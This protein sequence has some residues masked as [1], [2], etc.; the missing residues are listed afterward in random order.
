MTFQ[1][2]FL[3][4]WTIYFSF[5]FFLSSAS[6]A[7]CTKEFGQSHLYCEATRL[8]DEGCKGGNHSSS[9][10][11]EAE[12]LCEAVI[13]IRTEQSCNLMKR[14]WTR[15]ICQQMNL[16]FHG[17]PCN[18]RR[19]QESLDENS[20]CH[21]GS[22]L[23]RIQDTSAVCTAASNPDLKNV[24]QLASKIE[25]LN[26][27]EMKKN[28]TEMLIP[29]LERIRKPPYSIEDQQK[30]VT[31]LHGLVDF[32]EKSKPKW[33]ES[34]KT[35]GLSIPYE[36]N[37][38]STTGPVTIW[39]TPEGKPLVEFHE[40]SLG[41]GASKSVHL[42]IDYEKLVEKNPR[43]MLAFAE[44]V[45]T[46]KS[47]N[48]IHE[49]EAE[50]HLQR[51]LSKEANIVRPI[52]MNQYQRIRKTRTGTENRENLLTFASELYD[53]GNLSKLESHLKENPVEELK[54]QIAVELLDQ[55][56][57]IHKKD[58]SH[59]DIKP[60]N[61]LVRNL[62]PQSVD[63]GMSD[64]GSAIQLK[65]LTKDPKPFELDKHFQGTVGYMPPEA[66]QAAQD[67]DNPRFRDPA[68][69]K[70]GD[71]WAMGLTLYSL[72]HPEQSL[73]CASKAQNTFNVM[74]KLANVTNYDLL[75]Q[76]CGI[77]CSSEPKKSQ[78][79]AAGTLESVVYEMLNPDSA[80]RISAE[81]A[82][83]LM[84]EIYTGK[85]RKAQ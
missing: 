11:S 59:G 85:V 60:D 79:P 50:F 4:V 14:N 33:A 64:F 66:S 42:G 78:K 34:A 83:L 1:R 39:T 10:F 21:F 52:W 69:L 73:G 5:S 56:S 28:V 51:E 46:G 76:E 57:S 44:M 2:Y 65:Q 47:L 36:I 26:T 22:Y 35:R 53:G 38:S 3:K 71:V 37:V 17:Q 55:L 48:Q 23:K 32:I 25:L 15:L 16:G 40:L 67:P 68:L 45:T 12:I 20:L 31:F 54:N 41:K 24:S 8:A 70:K 58:V 13:L 80:K 29:T 7:D 6:F 62:K 75:C 72:N 27:F 77:F 84:K 82:H 49:M 19:T 30:L 63:V 61:I 81:Q 9:S 18:P 43:G 74:H